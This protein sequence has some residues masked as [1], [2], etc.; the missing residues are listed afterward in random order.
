MSQ[1]N[2]LFTAG[3][4]AAKLRTSFHRIDYVIRSRGIQAVQK[5]GGLRLFDNEALLQ[6]ETE[7]KNMNNNSCIVTATAE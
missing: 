4:I 7:L 5:A 2:K 6:I 1:S 3:E